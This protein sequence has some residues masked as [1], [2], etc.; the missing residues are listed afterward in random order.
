MS[1][2]SPTPGALLDPGVLAFSGNTVFVEA[3]YKNDAVDT[4]VR[5]RTSLARFGNLNPAFFLT[6]LLPLVMIL[7]FFNVIAGDRESGRLKAIAATGVSPRLWL[8]GKWLAAW[9]L[10]LICVGAVLSAVLL[11]SGGKHPAP[12]TLLFFAL[13]QLLYLGCVL[14]ITFLVSARANRSATALLILPAIWMLGS[15]AAPRLAANVAEARHPTP[16]ERGLELA[17]S[18]E[19]KEIL[20]D[21]MPALEQQ[22][23]E[24]HGV[25]DK[26]D[27]PINFN[28]LSMQ[29]DEEVADRVNDRHY[30]ELY[31]GQRDQVD[32][33]RAFSL[34]WPMIP[35]RFLSMGLAGT[36]MAAHHHF[37][38]QTEAY[39]RDFVKLL[40]DDMM[41]NSRTG[42][43]GYRAPAETWSRIPAYVHQPRP[44][45]AVLRD[46]APDLTILAAWFILSAG[47][48]FAAAGS[49]FRSGS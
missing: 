25:S 14:N 8:L 29:T 42:D 6:M 49:L 15:L 47:L 43:W 33:Y 38:Q 27:L 17:V 24:R 1:F 20:A 2:A 16:M 36:D 35:A 37:N 32:V 44:L 22:T 5:E 23:L 34:L 28:A 4:P 48:L 10:P 21:T 39:R 40:N 11:L 3:H 30:A 12:A 41:N 31:A 7:I 13:G 26:S 18:Q 19:K 45:E 46:A 9:L